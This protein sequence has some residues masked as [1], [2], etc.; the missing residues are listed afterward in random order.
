MTMH[1][2]ELSNAIW[3]EDDRGDNLA[4]Q[5]RHE[6]MLRSAAASDINRDA[7]LRAAKKSSDSK[8]KALKGTGLIGA[9]DP[10]LEAGTCAIDLHVCHH[11]GNNIMMCIH[12][13]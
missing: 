10:E 8:K 9:L 11:D 4:A 13:E 5:Q 6:E 3:R 2:F 7:A 1:M 12:A